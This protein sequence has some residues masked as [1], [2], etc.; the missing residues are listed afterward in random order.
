VNIVSL[1]DHP[2]FS[3]GLREALMAR[4]SAL[5]VSALTKAADALNYLTEHP[6]TDVFILDLEMPD[7]D[8]I[9]FMNAMESRS[10][11]TP[12]LIMTAKT[13]LALLKR[14]LEL[15]AMGVLPKTTP[16]DEVEAAL[17]QV[18]NGEIVL[19]ATISGALDHVSKYAEDNTDSV[20]STRQLEI[21]KM[22]QSGLRNQDIASVLFI[23]ERTVKSHLQT[24]FRILHARNRMDCVR[25]AE[26]LGIL[27]K[28]IVV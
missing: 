10:L 23:S 8:G 20:L 3:H 15:G 14:C 4:N 5:N 6:E 7:M 13:E 12:V 9:A 24:I 25:K 28:A 16:V 22:V 26:S 17:H 27:K 1:D 19:P 18:C 11:Y 2:I 21:L